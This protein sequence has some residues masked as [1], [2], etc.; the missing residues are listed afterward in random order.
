MLKVY[1]GYE[2]PPELL[3]G[4]RFEPYPGRSFNRVKKA[5]WFK[6]PLVQEII[7]NIDKAKV[8]MDFSV[9]SMITHTG[10]SVN[11]L[12]GGT[13]CLIMLYKNPEKLYF[14]SMGDNCVEYLEKI[15]AKF[16]EEG[17]DIIII[18][19]YLNR[20]QFKY[21]DSIEFLNWGIICHSWEEVDKKD[22]YTKWVDRARNEIFKSDEED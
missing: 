14:V 9:V 6:D 5:E 7:E 18:T 15:A 8:E 1:Y 13:K 12:A 17:K 19:D 11:D 16:E 3:N 22:I 10:F 20:F 21:I 2:A 4:K